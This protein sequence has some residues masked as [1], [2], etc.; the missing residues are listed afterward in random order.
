EA[1]P[2]AVRTGK[3]FGGR[4]EAEIENL[5]FRLSVG[6]CGDVGPAAGDLVK[7]GEE[8]D[9]G[10]CDVEEHLYDICPDNSCHPA[11]VGVENCES[12]NQP[13]GRH[14]SRAENNCDDDGNR[15]DANA[16]GEGTQDQEC[17]RSKAPEA[18]AEA[19]SHEFVG[20]K[21]F[22]AEIGG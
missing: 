6:D 3:E 15:E 21:H 11:F 22:P 4:T 1:S 18:I 19:A 17:S 10:S 2:K 9:D 13:D 14:F 8:A 5:K 12:H 7:N 16:F 20:R